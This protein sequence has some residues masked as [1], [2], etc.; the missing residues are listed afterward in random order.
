MAPIA[1]SAAQYT[2]ESSTR[3][4]LKNALFELLLQNLGEA[5]RLRAYLSCYKS[6]CSALPSDGKL[7]SLGMQTLAS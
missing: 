6:R 1:K 7:A 3:K 4:V 2:A 5:S